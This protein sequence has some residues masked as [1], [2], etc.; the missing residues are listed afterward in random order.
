[1]RVSVVPGKLMLLIGKD[2]LKVVEARFDLKNNIGIF[3]GAGDLQ[4]KVYSRFHRCPI[5]H[6]NGSFVPSETARPFVFSTSVTNEAFSVERLQ[7]SRTIRDQMISSG[8]GSFQRLHRTSRRLRQR[9]T[10]A[11]E[12]DSQVEEEVMENVV[13]DAASSLHQKTREACIVEDT[14]SI[15]LGCFE[16]TKLNRVKKRHSMSVAGWRSRLGITWCVTVDVAE[17][18]DEEAGEGEIHPSKR[19]RVAERVPIHVPLEV[20]N[21]DFDV[22]EF[23]GSSTN[24]VVVSVFG[25]S[26][27][28]RRAAVRRGYPVM[29]SRFLN[30]GDD[31][32]DQSVRERI[33]ATVQRIQPRLSVLACV[34]YR[35]QQGTYFSFV[36]VRGQ[37]SEEPKSPQETRQVLDQQSRTVEICQG[38]RG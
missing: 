21:H 13:M 36:H 5:R 12:Q 28:L 23:L 11:S 27:I 31:V 26:E 22:N 10:I 9:R 8:K 33:L 32:H 38:Q 37:G 20:E 2:T 35:K 14:A 16:N 34:K 25:D 29:K 7:G 4:G 24:P 15:D 3:P 6:G 19:Q 18:M 1:M 30:F 17:V